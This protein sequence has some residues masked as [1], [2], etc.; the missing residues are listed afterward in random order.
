MP[1][2]AEPRDIFCDRVSYVDLDPQRTDYVRYHLP[3]VEDSYVEV[4]QRGDCYKAGARVLGHDIPPNGSVVA[5]ELDENGNGMGDHFESEWTER[6]GEILAA[7][8]DLDDDD[9]TNIREFQWE[10]MPACLSG[11]IANCKDHERDQATGDGG[12]GWNDGLEV[13]YWNNPDNDG[14][15]AGS[16]LLAFFD[17][18]RLLDTDNDGVTNVNQVDS[19]NDD[20]ADGP[21]ALLYKSY[22]EFADSDCAAV[23]AACTPSSQSSYYDPDRQGSPGTGD[24]ISDHAELQAW[25]AIQPNAWAIDFDEDGILSNLL[26][27]DSDGDGLRDGDELGCSDCTLAY[28]WDTDG[29]SLLDGADQLIDSTD[30]RWAIYDDYGIVFTDSGPNARVYRGEQAAGTD[31]TNADSDGDGMPD[32]WEVKHNLNPVLDDASG[33]LDEDGYLD[34]T[35]TNLQEYRYGIPGDWSIAVDGVWW[36]GTRPNDSDTDDDGAN[37]GVEVHYGSNPTDGASMDPRGAGRRDPLAMAPNPMNEDLDRDEMDQT[38]LQYLEEG[39]ADAAGQAN[40][41]V[42]VVDELISAAIAGNVTQ[43]LNVL[44]NATPIGPPVR[45]AVQTVLLAQDAITNVVKCSPVPLPAVPSP[46]SSIEAPNPPPD[47]ESIVATMPGLGRVVSDLAESTLS[48]PMEAP[49]WQDILASTMEDPTNL[50]PTAQILP[51]NA[52]ESLSEA[53]QSLTPSLQG[54]AS[55]ATEQGDETAGCILST[56]L[57]FLD[58]LL[59]RTVESLPI[60]GDLVAKTRDETLPSLVETADQILP[61]ELQATQEALLQR[62]LGTLTSTALGLPAYATDPHN[63]QEVVANTSAMADLLVNSI[64]KPTSRHPQLLHDLAANNGLIAQWEQVASYN[65]QLN[66]AS[67]GRLDAI[68]AVDSLSFN[69]Y[70]E[71]G[72]TEGITA[73]IPGKRTCIQL[74]ASTATRDV[75]GCD[76]YVTASL[77]TTAAG[78]TLLAPSPGTRLVPTLLLEKAVP[79]ATIDAVAFGYFQLPASPFIAVLGFEPTQGNIPSSLQ[80]SLHSFTADGGADRSMAVTFGHSSSSA[81]LELLAAAYKVD[82]STEAKPVVPGHE[83]VLRVVSDQ[84]PSQ[85]TLDIAST[86]ALTTLSAEASAAARVDAVFSETMDGWSAKAALGANLASGASRLQARFGPQQGL[87]WTWTAP[88]L[89]SAL[90]IAYTGELV[91]G[92]ERAIQV[93]ATNLP[94]TVNIVG[95]P[96]VHRY[97][98]SAGTGAEKLF[99]VQGYGTKTCLT[100]ATASR[101][102]LFKAADDSCASGVLDTVQALTVE[103]GDNLAHATAVSTTSSALSIRIQ[104]SNPVWAFVNGATQW[105]SQLSLAG[106]ATQAWTWSATS[107][108]SEVRLEALVDH[109]SWQNTMALHAHNLPRSV[110][111]TIDLRTG[112][113]SLDASGYIGDATLALTNTGN[114]PSAGGDHVRLS[115]LDDAVGKLAES[116]WKVAQARSLSTRLLPNGTVQVSGDLSAPR[117]INAIFH[118]AEHHVVLNASAANGRFDY[119]IMEDPG[120]GGIIFKQ[121]APASTGT[122]DVFAVLPKGRLETHVIGAPARFTLAG[123]LGDQTVNIDASSF[124][125]RVR[126]DYGL[127]GVRPTA[128]A[129][130]NALAMQLLDAQQGGFQLDASSVRNLAAHHEAGRV[131]FNSN[132]ASEAPLA[133]RFQDAQEDVLLT[134]TK[135]PMQATVTHAP[136]SFTW[137]GTAPATFT[138]KAAAPGPRFLAIEADEAPS[139]LTGTWTSPPGDTFDAGLSHNGASRLARLAVEESMTVQ[140]PGGSSV[141]EGGWKFAGLHLPARVQLH[142][143]PQDSVLEVQATTAAGAVATAGRITASYASSAGSLPVLPAGTQGALLT[144]TGTSSSAALSFEGLQGLTMRLAGQ[145]MNATEPSMITLDRTTRSDLILKATS[146]RTSTQASI[147]VADATPSLDLVVDGGGASHDLHIAWQAATNSGAATLRMVSPG[148]DIGLLAEGTPQGVPQGFQ[149]DWTPQTPFVLT[150]SAAFSPTLQ[151]AENLANAPWRDGDFAAIHLASTQSA[152]PRVGL[153]LTGTTGFTLDAANRVLASSD[154]GSN[155]SFMAD[156]REPNLGFQA[157]ASDLPSTTQLT[158]DPVER[159]FQY[160][161]SQAVDALRVSHYPASDKSPRMFFALE[162]SAAGATTFSQ[163]LDAGTFALDRPAASGRVRISLDNGGAGVLQSLDEEGLFLDLADVAKVFLVDLHGVRTASG[164]MPATGAPSISLLGDS[165]PGLR[166]GMNN[167]AQRITATESGRNSGATTFTWPDPSDTATMRFDADGVAGR[168][169][170]MG[171]TVGADSVQAGLTDSPSHWSLQSF[172]GRSLE[173]AGTAPS[174]GTLSASGFWH[175]ASFNAEA[176]QVGIDL[177]VLMDSGFATGIIEAIGGSPIRLTASLASPGAST[178]PFVTTVPGDALSVDSTPSGGILYANLPKPSKITW[179]LAR[180]D[181]DRNAVTVDL[182]LAQSSGSP[183]VLQF[184]DAQHQTIYRLLN[185][186]TPTTH[187]SLASSLNDWALHIDSA[188]KPVKAQQQGSSCTLEVA[189]QEPAGLLD[190]VSNPAGTTP[191]DVTGSGATGRL[192]VA[193]TCPNGFG[194]PG[195]EAHLQ[196][197][198]ARFTATTA[199]AFPATG[200]VTTA[201]TGTVGVADLLMLPRGNSANRFTSLADF[202]AVAVADQS[203]YAALKIRNLEEVSWTN[204]ADGAVEATLT[205]SAPY[206]GL[207]SVVLQGETQDLTARILDAAAVVGISAEEAS[208]TYSSEGTSRRIDATHVDSGH[209]VSSYVEG[210]NG[211]TTIEATGAEP[212]RISVTAE[213]VEAALGFKATETGTALSAGTSLNLEVKSPI[214]T[215]MVA[216]VKRGT[217]GATSPDRLSISTL[218]TGT[219]GPIFVQV[220][221]QSRVPADRAGN[222][223]TMLCDGSSLSMGTRLPF[224]RDVH[225]GSGSCRG[226]EAKGIPANTPMPI[227]QSDER[228]TFMLSLSSQRPEGGFLDFVGDCEGLAYWFNSTSSG[229]ARIATLDFA[230]QATKTEPAPGDS[231]PPPCLRF[232][233]SCILTMTVKGVDLPGQANAAFHGPDGSSQK[234]LVLEGGAGKLLDI[235]LLLAR[236]PSTNSDGVTDIGIEASMP[237][238]TL[239]FLKSDA[240][241]PVE[242]GSPNQILQRDDGKEDTLFVKFE[243]LT[244]ATID[245]HSDRDAKLFQ[246]DAR[247]EGNSRRALDYHAW[248]KACQEKRVLV[249]NLPNVLDL[250]V[251]HDGKERNLVEASESTQSIP[252][253]MFAMQNK[254]GCESNPDKAGTVTFVQAR[255]IPSEPWTI[256]LRGGRAGFVRVLSSGGPI[257]DLQ[258]GLSEAG[259]KDR[260]ATIELRNVRLSLEWDLDGASRYP[261][262]PKYFYC[263]TG[264]LG[265]TGSIGARYDKFGLRISGGGTAGLICSSFQ[266]Q[267]GTTAIPVPCLSACSSAEVLLPW[268]KFNG[269]LI[270]APQARPE[271]LIEDQWWQVPR[272]W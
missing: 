214:P 16:A 243:K 99:F 157:V 41:T 188:G 258:V 131:T 270:L 68:S 158:W 244:S 75:S 27:P 264:N 246:L 148:Q 32:G 259:Q 211:V 25:T 265:A 108:A 145:G 233:K 31:A 176:V 231:P 136:G 12:D 118:D 48:R 77:G 229:S 45:E 161:G 9:L 59:N 107:H 2:E 91:G 150:T 142:A 69:L 185:G 38:N 5:G 175:D 82:E 83:A 152:P 70:T 216:E 198:P 84:V 13:D 272:A 220:G 46:P 269:G 22:P 14:P 103:S 223:L 189:T 17:P 63:L 60:V 195:L 114:A 178:G 241:V 71:R 172:N 6:L 208:M 193:T 205:R 219:A 164:T 127:G 86:S 254:G 268:F 171:E 96:A 120:F 94:S 102:F 47:P 30:P 260:Y 183:L 129:A 250:K 40:E 238:E 173:Y 85:L 180:P 263:D 15:L 207:T 212:A 179:D 90:N 21:E 140:D 248:N 167:G 121:K 143:A 227:Q 36:W 162:D 249:S 111:A 29:D 7:A 235:R 257:G 200:L 37:D 168:A 184:V 144:Q 239:R 261:G 57:P 262:S 186:A 182:E 65:R 132:F 115:A 149:V 28:H 139:S 201:G 80:A 255:N 79:T 81:A 97:L 74:D 62:P 10:L 230:F 177:Q 112:Q 156:Y 34:E 54:L 109:D 138:F 187:L 19:D 98:V 92:K 119:W 117:S 88:A 166:L 163:D 197:V 8:D 50:L 159:T 67:G 113:A 151:F 116:S 78:L 72:G 204:P 146:E 242:G 105:D 203:S 26:D 181:G 134:S 247:Y 87:S 101:S 33:D 141:N 190:V 58:A 199:G 251:V 165:G 228:G 252:S 153:R 93:N 4:D 210:I 160:Y 55:N 126:F 225:L 253:V 202:L 125:G 20:L 100:D 39:R 209:T 110:N 147:H 192:D 191:L 35:W 106:N 44:Y 271:A 61:I 240:S 194:Q 51:E 3:V 130:T 11:I 53:Q 267:W 104:D 215:R 236:T 218:E 232:Q 234:G 89:T 155:P 135:P 73:A 137:S 154:D 1:V 23:T 133:L 76:L 226:F 24:G 245:L 169:V 42:Q 222:Y 56:V 18:D 128:P 206:T 170:W 64:I 66:E 174:A 237:L 95:D 221:D 123:T 256:G 49:R 266:V 196:Q 224:V 122:V 52:V 124:I 213:N 217:C 43:A